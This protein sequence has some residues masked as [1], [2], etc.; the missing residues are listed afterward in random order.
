MVDPPRLAFQVRFLMGGWRVE[1]VEMSGQAT[2]S[3]QLAL[4]TQTSSR[5]TFTC[6]LDERLLSSGRQVL[7][8]AIRACVAKVGRA[9]TA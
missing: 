1:I 5:H 7:E 2:A 9:T 6:M 4:S 3:R 8:M